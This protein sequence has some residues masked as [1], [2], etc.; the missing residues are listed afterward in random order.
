MHAVHP[1]GYSAGIQLVS[2]VKYVVYWVYG[3]APQ[4]DAV[5]LVVL[6]QL[7]ACS[8]GGSKMVEYLELLDSHQHHSYYDF[9][10]DGL[11]NTL[12]TA[13]H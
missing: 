13:G 11:Y 8:G 3:M 2:R 10:F 7:A 6:S 9:N 5:Q 1:G 4:V 12:P